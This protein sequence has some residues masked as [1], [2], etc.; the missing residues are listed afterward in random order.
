MLVHLK[1]AQI[2][3][4]IILL[5]KNDKKVQ[6]KKPML[7]LIIN[8]NQKFSN[9]STFWDQKMFPKKIALKVKKKSLSFGCCLKER[10]K[11][12]Q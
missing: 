5:D 9:S 3:I 8:L 12:S 11:Q 1:T 6:Q 4:L 10:A 7:L 2:G